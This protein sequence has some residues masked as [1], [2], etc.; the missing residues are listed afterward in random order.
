MTGRRDGRVQGTAHLMTAHRDRLGGCHCRL[1]ARREEF[2]HATLAVF[3]GDLADDFR[4][5]AHELLR[6]QP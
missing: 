2:G 3:V 1:G 5:P 4:S 6:A